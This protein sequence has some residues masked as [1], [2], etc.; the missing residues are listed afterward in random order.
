MRA[1]LFRRRPVQLARVYQRFLPTAAPIG[2]YTLVVDSMSIPIGLGN[3]VLTL[4]GVYSLIVD[5]LNIPV[6]LNQVNLIWVGAPI[7]LA[8]SSK[9]ALSMRI[10][11]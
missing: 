9:I 6:I 5:K 2:T 11:L 7:V 3:I 10:G 8:K 4:T 1:S